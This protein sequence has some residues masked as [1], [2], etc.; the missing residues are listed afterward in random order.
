MQNQEQYNIWELEFIKCGNSSKKLRNYIIKYKNISENPF[1]SKAKE[2]MSENDPVI[3]RQNNTE[4]K[5]LKEFDF[6]SVL[7]L[8]GFIGFIALSCFISD[9]WRDW[10]KP[11]TTKDSDIQIN[12]PAVQ[13]IYPI[14]N[15]EL[16]PS[17]S[18]SPDIVPNLQPQ[19][20]PVPNPSPY[21]SSSPQTDQD[22]N[23]L[24]DVYRS[25]YAEM[26]RQAE[27]DYNSLTNLG[28]RYNNN[29]TPDGYTGRTDP[30]VATQISFFKQLQHRMR[31]L[32]FEASKQGVNISQSYWETANV[33]I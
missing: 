15:P 2:L 8:F 30:Y 11:N 22:I 33:N 25:Q 19:S 6:T 16:S 28:I 24:D 7:M 27:R 20:Y 31:D 13:S 26:E 12:I 5:A 10:I 17:S 32:R 14:S 3:S 18:T 4:I 9:N 29:G 23:R 1:V 21:F